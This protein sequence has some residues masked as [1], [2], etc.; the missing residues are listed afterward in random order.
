MNKPRGIRGRPEVWVQDFLR[1]MEPN[2]VPSSPGSRSPIA[3]SNETSPRSMASASNMPVS[4]FVIEPTSK[5]V[6]GFCVDAGE[7]DFG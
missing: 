2:S 7:L 6:S 3:A 4:P 1:E 5:S